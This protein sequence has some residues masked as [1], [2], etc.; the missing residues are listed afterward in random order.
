MQN[1]PHSRHWYATL[2]KANDPQLAGKVISDTR[3][4]FN[5]LVKQESP[6]EV[7]TPALKKEIHNL[8]LPGLAIY[9]VIQQIECDSNKALLIVEGL[10]KE[11]FFRTMGFCIRLINYLP[12]PFPLVRPALRM[13][14]KKE[15]IPGSQT[16]IE[17]N[18]NCFALNTT[19][20]FKWDVLNALNASDLTTLYC[21]TDDWLSDFLPKVQW[22]R[23]KTLAR[24]DEL[25]DFRW[26]R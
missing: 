5:Q 14:T 12:D 16:V 10:F 6:V 21:K 15:Y 4:L 11:D 19:R 22:M 20:C 3:I 24:G 7:K 17:D 18:R 26:C 25:C 13:M 9:Q 1:M 2:S 8:I 23:T